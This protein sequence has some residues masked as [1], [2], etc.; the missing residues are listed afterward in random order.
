MTE[1]SANPGSQK[2]E[3]IEYW[4]AKYLDNKEKKLLDEEKANPKKKE[5]IEYW[6]V[7]YLERKRLAL[8]DNLYEHIKNLNSG[9]IN[10]FIYNKETADIQANI[11]D[12][13]VKLALLREHLG[14]V[15]KEEGVEYFMMKHQE[16]KK[17]SLVQVL[18]GLTSDYATGKL[19]KAGYDQKSSEIEG[20]LKA[21]SAKANLL[22]SRLDVGKNTDEKAEA[23]KPVSVKAQVT[24][25]PVLIRQA[26]PEKKEENK[27]KKAEQENTALGGYEHYKDDIGIL[28]VIKYIIIFLA[29]GGIILHFYLNS[30]C[31]SAPITVK[32]PDIL[33]LLDLIRDESPRDY[34]MLCKYSTGIDYLGGAKSMSHSNRIMISD[35]SLGYNENSNKVEKNDKILAGNIVHE[36]CHNMMYCLMGGYGKNL[37]KDVER[38]CERMRYMFMYREG[39][40]KSYS[41]MVNAL[42]LEEYG[43][44]PLQTA[45]ISA[46]FRQTDT[47]KYYKYGFLND[48][49]EKAKLKTERVSE[50]TGEYRLTFQNTGEVNIH[51]GT[52]EL[53][54]NEV[55][56]PLNCFDLA[57][58]EKYQTGKDFK[59]MSGDVN[60]V[61]IVGCQ[62]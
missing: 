48:Y 13:D 45:G 36:A 41:E 44:K 2:R 51:C 61:R 11:K 34:E 40:Y 38:P 25:K 62:T 33:A 50:N 49:C 31:V 60:S 24:S 14:N 35:A 59:L 46:V 9:K 32:A 57:P 28:K 53:L 4:I 22:R 5:E 42:A 7:R 1:P 55:E 17:D 30:H 47:E 23:E 8:I 39:Y 27:P 10:L 20:Q 12:I 3:D 37:E 58:G 15:R 54:V 52:I 29:I 19:D 16:E 43:K 21:V 18:Y 56:Y 26:A 6:M